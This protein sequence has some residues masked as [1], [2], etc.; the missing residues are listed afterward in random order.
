MLVAWQEVEDQLAALHHLAD[1][2]AA[3]DAAAESA[4]SSAY[5]AE[6]RYEGGIA[7]YIEVT[8]TQSAALQAQRAALD[9]RVRRLGAAVALLRALGGDWSESALARAAA[10]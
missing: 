8:S 9:A 4:K 7:D 10:R 5:H 3:E 1:E 6:R 2:A